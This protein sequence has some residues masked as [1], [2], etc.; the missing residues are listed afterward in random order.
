MKFEKTKLERDI[1][2]GEKLV[3]AEFESVDG[4]LHSALLTFESGK[5]VKMTVESY[6]FQVLVP[7]KPKMEDA[8]RVSGKL[9]GTDLTKVF[10]VYSNAQTY[11]DKLKATGQM[12]N[13]SGPDSIK[14]PE[15]TVLEDSVLKGNPLEDEIPF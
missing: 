4:S 15:G 5:I 9:L 12:D 7:A 14:V 11:Y 1:P 3:K 6:S 10:E 13:L 2:V 8:Y